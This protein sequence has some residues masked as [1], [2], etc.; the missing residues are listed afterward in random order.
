MPYARDLSAFPLRRFAEVLATVE[1]IP[2]RRILADHIA[3][4]AARLETNGVSDLE[5][6]RKLLA[7]KERYD[8]LSRQLGVD[9]DY[10]TLLNRE[11]NSYKT[12]PVPLAKLE[13]LTDSE[14]A[15][16]DG[17]GISST[18]ALYDRCADKRDRLALT[19][20]LGIKI[21]RLDE[22][23]R[24]AN[25]VRINGVGPAF[26]RFFLD[27]GVLGPEDVRAI[28]TDEIIRRYEASIADDPDQPRL[29]D[30]DIQYCKRYCEGL[31]DDIEW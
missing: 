25:L 31:Q 24:L 9:A 21:T 1:L 18:R 12:K 19:E 15:A 23:L 16:L 22:V 8:R 2:S 28:A 3:D 14:L 10:L 17:A 30:E 20:E 11:V 26:A 7:S 27:L 13:Y 29:L 6:L 5:A 4:V